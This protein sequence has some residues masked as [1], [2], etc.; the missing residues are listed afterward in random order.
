VLRVRLKRKGK[1]LIQRRKGRKLRVRII[2]RNVQRR[3]VLLK[4]GGRSKAIGQR[5]RG[6]RRA[7]F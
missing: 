1:R 6:H 3:R 4:M 5:N 7:G 2:G